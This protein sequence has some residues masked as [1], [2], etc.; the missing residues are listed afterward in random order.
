[1]NTKQ[2]GNTFEREI[3]KKLSLF[4][5]NNEDEYGCWRTASSGGMTTINKNKKSKGLENQSG[6]IKQVIQKGIYK[7]LD[8]FF[9]K[10]FVECK[11]LKSFDLTPPYNKEILNII[12][13][14]QNE[15]KQCNKFIF[16]VVKRNRKDILIFTDSITLFGL[17]CYSTYHFENFDLSCYLF[18]DYISSKK[19]P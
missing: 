8:E 1:M 9:D 7:D 18:N 19:V 14:L 16:L 11:S 17:K 4:L 15:K 13:Q 10:Y 3:A 12:S 5:T 2:K 6:D